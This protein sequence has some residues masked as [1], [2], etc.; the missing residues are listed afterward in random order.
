MYVSEVGSVLILILSVYLLKWL[1]CFFPIV[2]INLLNFVVQLVNVTIITNVN[3]TAHQLLIILTSLI[4]MTESFS[5]PQLIINSQF[6]N[7]DE[8]ISLL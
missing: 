4:S 1:V 7:S 5:L 3:Q 6:L 2:C 8:F